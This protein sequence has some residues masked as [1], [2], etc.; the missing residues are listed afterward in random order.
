MPGSKTKSVTPKDTG[1]GRFP[2]REFGINQAW[3]ALTMIAADLVAWLRLLALKDGAL[4]KA[5]PKALRYRLLHVP[6]RLIHGPRR[7]RPRL[8][9][10]WPWVADIVAAFAR[11]AAIP[12]PA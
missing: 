9:K 12:Q 11:I 4:A 6:A 1:L 7:R 3:L 8:P 2:S 5:E 10:I